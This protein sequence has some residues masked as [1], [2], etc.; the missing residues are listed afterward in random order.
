M[1][2]DGM[3]SSSTSVEAATECIEKRIKRETK[4]VA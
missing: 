2:E 3:S 1:D 4:V